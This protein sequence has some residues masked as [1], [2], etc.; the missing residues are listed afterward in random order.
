[1]GLSGRLV[2]E[3]TLPMVDPTDVVTKLHPQSPV[4]MIQDGRS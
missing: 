4:H 2:S 3:A 1:V